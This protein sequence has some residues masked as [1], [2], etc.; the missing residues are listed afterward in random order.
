MPTGTARAKVLRRARPPLRPCGSLVGVPLQTWL[1]VTGAWSPVSPSDT[2]PALFQDTLS[3]AV[4][5]AGVLEAEA[6]GAS[7]LWGLASA[8]LGLVT[9]TSTAVLSSVSWFWFPLYY[10]LVYERAARRQQRPICE[11]LASGPD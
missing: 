4:Q 10:F 11:F 6:W 1:A 7:S 5:T 8:R 3:L 9:A 2:C